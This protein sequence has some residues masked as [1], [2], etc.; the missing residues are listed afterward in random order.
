MNFKLKE[1][2]LSLNPPLQAWRLAR[3]IGISPQR[4][5]DIELEKYLP[6]HKLKRK[7]A[8]ALGRSVT[9]LFETNLNGDGI[10]EK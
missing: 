4:L 3:Q 7:I 10:H 9:S 1:A 2:R 6:D 8:K 5:S